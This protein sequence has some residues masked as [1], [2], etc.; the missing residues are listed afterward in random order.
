MTV[1]ASGR[2]LGSIACHPWFVGRQREVDTGRSEHLRRSE[3]GRCG[4]GG[5]IPPSLPQWGESLA[6]FFLQRVREPT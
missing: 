1:I 5:E 6:E 3:L 2:A 4:N